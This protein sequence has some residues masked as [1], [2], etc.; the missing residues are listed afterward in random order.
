MGVDEPTFVINKNDAPSTKLGVF[1][2]ELI[3]KLKA[4]EEGRANR[5]ATES[6]K[7]AH[8]TLLMVLSNL[9][10]F[11]PDIDLADGFKKPPT[12]AD[13]QAAKE[14]AA[15]LAVKALKI[16]TTPRS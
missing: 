7:L 13:I 4:H 15:P 3:E 1:F 11:H 8:D 14:K 10:C 2:N 6:W 12:S 16:Q 9:A 5:F